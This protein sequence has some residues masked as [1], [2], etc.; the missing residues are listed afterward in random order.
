MH[1]LLSNGAS[2]AAQNVVDAL[3]EGSLTGW[4]LLAAAV[5]A[6]ASVPG[7]RAVAAIVK[8]SLRRAGVASREVA[9]DL[10]RISKWLVYLLAFALVASIMGID[11]GFL[12]V[13]FAFALI[14]G[15][16]ALKPMVENSAS[17]I[18]LLARPSFSVGDQIKSSEFRGT[19]DNIGSRSTTLRQSDGVLV[20]ISNNQV[21]G[22]P[23]TVYSSTKGRKA[24]FD[25]SVPSNTDLD[26]ITSAVTAAISSVDDVL[27]DPGPAVEASGITDNAI[28]LTISY[29]YPATMSG[30]SGV[31]D[32]AIRATMSALHTAHIELSVPERTLMQPEDADGSDT[33]SSRQSDSSP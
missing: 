20:F 16:L 19:V 26:A 17:G 31:T 22:N 18:L 21:L 13:L 4:D 1:A 12:S 30:S 9:A 6:V 33:R 7:A 27:D 25:I 15:A 23:I 28:T 32:G 14:I 5:V 11:I 3:N 10:A 2:D 29:W 8:R 24:S